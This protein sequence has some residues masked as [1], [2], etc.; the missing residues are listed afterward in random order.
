[1]QDYIFEF[2]SITA[3]LRALESAP[4]LSLAPYKKLTVRVDGPYNGHSNIY[5][6]NNGWH[7]TNICPTLR[8]DRDTVWFDI[9]YTC[10]DC[11]DEPFA[12]REVNF[13]VAT[14]LRLFEPMLGLQC[15]RP[16]YVRTFPWRDGHL[17]PHFR[18][19]HRSVSKRHPSGSISSASSKKDNIS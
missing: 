1:M 13:A 4:A 9:G 5:G 18:A 16:V 7:R 2:T 6:N 12:Q 3:M 14:L 19:Y 10:L 8:R 15:P 17:V 11:E